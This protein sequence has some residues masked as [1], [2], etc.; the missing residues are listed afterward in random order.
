MTAQDKRDI[1]LNE[2]DERDG[3]NSHHLDSHPL[4]FLS[5]AMAAPTAS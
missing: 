2:I 1:R 3:G 4:P 5:F